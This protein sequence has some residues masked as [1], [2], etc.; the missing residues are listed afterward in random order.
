MALQPDVASE[1]SGSRGLTSSL[2]KMAENFRE[3]VATEINRRYIGIKLRNKIREKVNR[4]M[5]RVPF[6]T[7]YSDLSRKIGNMVGKHWQMVR[8]HYTHIQ[9]LQ[10]PPLLSY[11][12]AKKPK[13][14]STYFLWSQET[15]S[16]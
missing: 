4:R 16:V 13:K 1:E 10:H 2:D 6:V 14:E 11:H 7:T 12:R 8:A 15:D 9:E 3:R 5:T